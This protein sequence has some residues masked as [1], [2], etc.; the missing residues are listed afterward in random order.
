MIEA[1]VTIKNRA[2]MHTRPASMI[3]KLAARYK[4]NFYIIKDNYQINGKSIIG[5][6]SLAAEYGSQL[7]LKFDGPDEEKASVEMIKYFEDGFGEP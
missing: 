3:V 4:S 2:G 1:V 7:T 5:I 6:M